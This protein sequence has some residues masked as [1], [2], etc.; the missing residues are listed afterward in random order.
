MK[1]ILMAIL[2]IILVCNISSCSGNDN[3]SDKNIGNHKILITISGDISAFDISESFTGTDTKG[4]AQLCDSL[5]KNIGS[6]Y[7]VNSSEENVSTISVSTSDNGTCLIGAIGWVSKGTGKS[8]IIK[9]YAYMNGKIIK[10]ESKTINSENG[11]F[12]FSTEQ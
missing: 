9:S 8:I 2:G 10:T 4:S 11:N 3:I 12:I 5:G 6:I 1:R 7:T